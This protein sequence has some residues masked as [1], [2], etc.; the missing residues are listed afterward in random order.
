MFIYIYYNFFISIIF[1]DQNSDN[2]S[3]KKKQLFLK[4]IVKLQIRKIFHIKIK[5]NNITFIMLL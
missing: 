5:F 2:A 3:I 4:N 1:L